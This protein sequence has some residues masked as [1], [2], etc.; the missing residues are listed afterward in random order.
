MG[1][2][3]RS[4]EGEVPRHPPTNTT[5]LL[6]TGLPSTSD[7]S[8][9]D[10]G[11]EIQHENDERA[12]SFSMSSLAEESNRHADDIHDTQRDTEDIG[13]EQQ[14]EE[15]MVVSQ[16]SEKSSDVVEM[17]DEGHRPSRGY[18]VVILRKA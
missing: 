5:L 17:R 3:V 2:K 7:S 10:A 11:D 9:S 13:T 18:V 1:G 15:P 16:V 14:K 8:D 12:N 6:N 4:S